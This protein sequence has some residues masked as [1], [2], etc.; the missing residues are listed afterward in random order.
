[1]HEISERKATERALVRKEAELRKLIDGLPIGVIIADYPAAQHIDYINAQI[2][3]TYG[4]TLED[5]PTTEDWFVKAYPDAD[6]RRQVRDIW[7]QAL[8][9]SAERQGIIGTREVR[10]RSRMVRA[11]PP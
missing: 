9:R 10:I 1:M 11:A 2:A 6:Y 5:V 8:R 4:Y 7:N 3:R